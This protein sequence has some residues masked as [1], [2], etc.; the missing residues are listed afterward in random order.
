MERPAEIADQLAVIR[1]EGLHGIDLPPPPHTQRGVDVF[2]RNLE[3]NI[4]KSCQY[5]RKAH[6]R[7]PDLI[8]PRTFTE[9]QL[10]FK[11]FGPIPS[12]SP[13]DKLRSC[14]YL[15][16]ELRHLI[17]LPERFA[18]TDR[19]RVPG[20]DEVAP[21]SYYFKSNHSSRTNARVSYPLTDERRAALQPLAANWI[22]RVHHRKLAL[23]WYETM[24]R[25]LYLE[26]DLGSDTADAPD[27]KF[28]VCNGKVEIFQV[29]VDRSRDHVQTLYDRDGRYL[30]QEL[31]YKT[32]T[33]VPMHD[34]LDDMI[35]VAEGIGRNFDF[36]RVDMFLKDGRIILGEIGLVP[37]GA[38]AKVR[39]DAL[40]ERLGAA[41]H[42]PWFGR[43]KPG[44]PGAH[45]D[46][47]KVVDWPA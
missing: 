44:F 42:A 47:I 14:A 10:L 38:G 46:R 25:N 9:K 11:F 21:G 29:D 12:P 31:Y 40:D 30:P 45:Y 16:V 15:P 7:L 22:S 1:A 13:S 34:R 24:P 20:N 36:I 2:G 27:W 5:Y 35:A 8:A 6:Q 43:V 23:W 19:A 17:H 28:F 26:E 41:W 18:I 32:G 33:P 3:A 37:N 39:S 4:R